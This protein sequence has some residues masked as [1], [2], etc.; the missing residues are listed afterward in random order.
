[1]EI[2]LALVQDDAADVPEVGEAEAGLEIKLY[3][4]A[5][6]KGD[7]A[8][9]VLRRVALVAGRYPALQPA[10]VGGGGEQEQ[11]E[12]GGSRLAFPVAPAGRPRAWPC[13]DGRRGG[14]A[15][16]EQ[17]AEL[18]DFFHCRV[19]VGVPRVARQPATELGALFLAAVLGMQAHA[20]VSGV[21]DQG[22]AVGGEGC[23]HRGFR[24]RLSSLLDGKALKLD[25][26]YY[27]FNDFRL[28]TSPVGFP[29]RS[30]IAL[31]R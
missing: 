1:M 31:T 3:L 20:P 21:L 9:V 16:G 29:I 28:P 22:V 30:R 27:K 12:R 6:G 4:A 10:Q 18:P 2:G 19:F 17:L 23:L 5:V 8:D 14:G 13:L 15:A 24:L 7:V 25:E 26:N 11:G